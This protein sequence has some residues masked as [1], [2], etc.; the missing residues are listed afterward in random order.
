MIFKKKRTKKEI[1]QS[2]IDWTPSIK[3]PEETDAVEKISEGLE[4]ISFN[5]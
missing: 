5:K 3:K 4:A 1:T 2:N